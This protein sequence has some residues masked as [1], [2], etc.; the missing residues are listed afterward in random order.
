MSKTKCAKGTCDLIPS[1][2]W[3]LRLQNLIEYR[4][5]L[6]HH[7]HHHHHHHSSLLGSAKKYT[8]AFASENLIFLLP[9]GNKGL[10]YTSALL[11]FTLQSILRQKK[12]LWKLKYFHHAKIKSSSEK[13][14]K[15]N[16]NP[17]RYYNSI[18]DLK[19]QH[20]PKYHLSKILISK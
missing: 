16:Q 20:K 7:H 6:H 10:C 9:L 14:S 3:R 5:R 1:G 13:P 8:S 15:R 18:T 12:N 4:R 19:F 17:S 2:S 11:P